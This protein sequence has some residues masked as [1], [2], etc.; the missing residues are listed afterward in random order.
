MRAVQGILG[1]LGTMEHAVYRAYAWLW[2]VAS[3]LHLY[4]SAK[5]K[6]TDHGGR[7]GD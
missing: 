6:T 7:I 4:V 1:T 5:R 3:V 2:A